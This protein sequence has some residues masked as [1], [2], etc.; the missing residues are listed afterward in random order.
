MTE[1][2]VRWVMARKAG[3]K[4]WDDELPFSERL[5]KHKGTIP[6]KSVTVRNPRVKSLV[7]VEGPTLL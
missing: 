4:N 6:F 1:E 3:R 7:V 5:K 2:G